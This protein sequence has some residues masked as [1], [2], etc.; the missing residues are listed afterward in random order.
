MDMVFINSAI[1]TYR[2]VSQN[3]KDWLVV[4]GVPLVE[5][6]LNGRLVTASEFG[7]YVEGWNG[8]PIVVNHPKL[9]GGSARVPSPD[10]T[11]AGAFYNARVD[12]ANRLVGEF[13]MDKLA[14][15]RDPKG[16]VILDNIKANRQIEVSTGYYSASYPEPGTWNGQPFALVDREL[17][18]DHIALLTNQEGACSVKDG[19]GLNRNMKQNACD[20]VTCD[21]RNSC[22][23]SQV[24]ANA[25]QASDKTMP[26]D[27]ADPIQFGLKTLYDFVNQTKE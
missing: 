12:N 15:S 27:E 5:G 11:V 3:G 20:C 9:N 14:L 10:V 25:D 1:R 8:R 2:E 4:S 18:P 26:A 23:R 13:W 7:K 19:C 17:K 6:V 24:L 16:Q 22:E 21:K